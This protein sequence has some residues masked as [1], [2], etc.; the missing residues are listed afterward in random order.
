MN[1]FHSY[2][3]VCCHEFPFEKLFVFTMTLV[4]AERI[5]FWNGWILREWGA[6]KLS[7]ECYSDTLKALDWI[8]K[9]EIVIA[10]FS[11]F[12]PHFCIH[13]W[14][15]KNDVSLSIVPFLLLLLKTF[16]IRGN[17]ATCNC[18]LTHTHTQFECCYCMQIIA[19][20]D[21][22]LSLLT[23]LQSG[24]LFIYIKKFIFRKIKMRKIVPSIWLSY[25]P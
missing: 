6:I 18:Y 10:T 12:P 8:G 24:F 25:Y 2:F 23:L 14:R 15:L 7:C 22:L 9:Y 21:S 19:Y 1:I 16:N 17:P 20:V 11:F 4:I 3:S 5:F 13:N